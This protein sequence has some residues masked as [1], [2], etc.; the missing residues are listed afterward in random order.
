MAEVVDLTEV[1]DDPPV[2]QLWVD[3]CPVAKPSVSFGPGRGTSGLW[4]RYID[5][6]VK[7][8]MNQLKQITKTTMARMGMQ[9]FPRR[10]PVVLKAWFFLRRPEDDFVGRRR[11]IG[12]LKESA[13]T[14]EETVVPIKADIDNMGKFLLDALT[15][16]LYEDDAQVV[17]LHMFKLRDSEGLCEGRMAIE[18]S[19]FNSSSHEVMP[20]F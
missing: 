17:E 19:T 20:K 4:R 7:N 12:R 5:T 9:K 11:G 16:S 2:I 10:T 14:M 3:M 8:K 6:G 18:C 15:G 13:A 1:Q